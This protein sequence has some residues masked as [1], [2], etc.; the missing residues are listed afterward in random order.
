M[1]WTSTSAPCP[2]P[3]PADLASVEAVSVYTGTACI[4]LMDGAHVSDVWEDLLYDGHDHEHGGGG[5]MMNAASLGTHFDHDGDFPVRVF[6][7]A[8]GKAVGLEVDLDPYGDDLD[9]LRRPEGWSS[10]DEHTHLHAEGVEHDHEHGHAPAPDGWSEPVSVSLVSN[11]ALL[12]DPAGLPEADD[13]GGL[14]DLVWPAGLG[15]VE[16]SVF[17]FGGVRR[18]LAVTWSH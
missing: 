9:S 1:S 15:K 8:D 3:V 14:F 11:H 12:G 4:A 2:L 7:N 10:E 16:A 5:L 18:L 17:T 6:R 13:T